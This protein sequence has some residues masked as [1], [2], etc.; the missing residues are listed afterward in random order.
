MLIEFNFAGVGDDGEP[1]FTEAHLR[2]IMNVD[3]TEISLDASN[4]RAGGRPAMLFHDP[5]LPA[6]IRSTAKSLLPCAGIFG[7]SAAGK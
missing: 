1:A 7:S 5:H 4:T 6:T 2:Q 3:E